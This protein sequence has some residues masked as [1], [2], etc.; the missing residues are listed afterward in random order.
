MVKQVVLRSPTGKIVVAPGYFGVLKHGE[1]LG[2]NYAP[3]TMAVGA[4]ALHFVRHRQWRLEACDPMHLLKN[5]ADI[6][7]PTIAIDSLAFSTVDPLIIDGQPVQTGDRVE[8]RSGV[9]T[10]LSISPGIWTAE[11]DRSLRLTNPPIYTM[12]S[13]NNIGYGWRY[14]VLEDGSLQGLGVLARTNAAG[15]QT[16]DAYPVSNPGNF[17]SSIGAN[18]A[19]LN[20]SWQ[21]GGATFDELQVRRLAVKATSSKMSYDTIYP[22]AHFSLGANGASLSNNFSNYET[23]AQLGSGAQIWST[24]STQYWVSRVYD[25]PKA[26]SKIGCSDEGMSRATVACEMLGDVA[27]QIKIGNDIPTNGSTLVIPASIADDFFPKIAPGN[28]T[29]LENGGVEPW[30]IQLQET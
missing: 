13:H 29:I 1:L 18:M 8:I 10:L 14:R 11:S 23:G 15:Y 27:C 12:S 6:V 19:M 20:A 9:A 16:R 24:G 5:A 21:G 22:K 26:I 7:N 28:Y 2:E 30:R 4:K 25:P 3:V 17:G